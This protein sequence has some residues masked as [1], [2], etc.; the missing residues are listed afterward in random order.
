MN[1]YSDYLDYCK[2]IHDINMSIAVLNWDLETKMPKNGHKFRAQQIST[3]RKISH[4]LSTNKSYGD[5]L[6]KLKNNNALD[7]DQSRNI[8]VSLKKYNKTLKY[9]ANFIENE[10]NLISEAFVKWRLAK[11]K[12]DFSIFEKSLEQLIQLRIKECE[13]L[14]YKNHPYDALLDQY[15]PDLTT[16]EVDKIFIEIKDFLIPFIKK[17]SNAKEIDDSFISIIIKKKT[18]GF[19]N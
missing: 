8:D 11:E 5:L 13:I 3:L 18:M 2:K 1:K 14:G 10:S 17:I 4:E 12:N 6:N 19:W 7:F 16:H 9:D 15:E